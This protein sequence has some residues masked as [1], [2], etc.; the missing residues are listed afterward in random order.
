MKQMRDVL[1]LSIPHCEAGIGKSILAP[2]SCDLI[3]GVVFGLVE[4]WTEGS[5]YRLDIARG[6]GDLSADAAVSGA[7]SYP[8]T[9]RAFRFSRG[10]PFFWTLAA[11]TLQVGLV[12][13][14]LDS[15]TFGVKNTLYGGTLRPIHI[16]IPPGVAHGYKVIDNRPAMLFEVA[17]ESGSLGDVGQIP[18]DDVSI[19]YEWG[20]AVNPHAARW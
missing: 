4:S 1:G 11:G 12:D 19:A 10:H 16:H 18:Y 8:G 2:N 9:V 14:R 13:L 17:E 7:M 5:G 15:A 6:G 20:T 3:E